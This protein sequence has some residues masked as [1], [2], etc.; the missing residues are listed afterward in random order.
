MEEKLKLQLQQLL[1]TKADVDEK[2]KSTQM[3]LQGIMIRND[4]IANEEVPET[5]EE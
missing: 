3:L 2:I 4:E 5:T 1:A